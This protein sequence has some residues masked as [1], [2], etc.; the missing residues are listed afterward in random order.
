[1]ASFMLLHA[2][3]SSTITPKKVRFKDKEDDMSVDMLTEPSPKHPTSW[4]DML[5]GHPSKRDSISS[6]GKESFDFLEGD[7]QRSVVNGVPSI[8]FSDRIH[9]ILIQGMDNTVVFKLLGHNI[10]FSALQNKIYSMW[11]PSGPIHMMD[12][13]N[14]YFLVKF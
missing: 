3:Q 11:R 9:Q 2:N 14:G 4:K 13:D 10:G 6:N 5:V 8:T 12:I 7:I 1:M